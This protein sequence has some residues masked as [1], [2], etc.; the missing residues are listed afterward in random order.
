MIYN[1]GLVSVPSFIRTH[2]FFVRFCSSLVR[3]RMWHIVRRATQQG[4]AVHLS[5]TYL[6]G[7]AHPKLLSQVFLL[8]IC[9]LFIDLFCFLGLHKWHM[10][11]PRLGAEPELH[12]PQPQQ[13]RIQAASVTSNAAHG[14]AGSLTHGARPGIEPASS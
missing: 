6:C 2:T 10:E 14:N 5:S 7:S 11:V 3:H 8:S 9:V 13:C 12:L 1:V 4:L